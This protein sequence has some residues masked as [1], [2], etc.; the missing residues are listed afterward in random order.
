MIARLISTALVVIGTFGAAQAQD[1]IAVGALRFVSNGP[2]FMAVEKGFFKAE[3][4]EVDIRFFD[5]A[6]P[7]AVAVVSGDVEL[8][9]TAFTAGLF[10]LA[11][12][13][14]L[15][16]IAAQAKE[17]KGYEGNNVLASNAAWE[18]GVRRLEDLPGKSLGI[19]QVGSSF[20][21]QIG[22]I[23]RLKGFDVKQVDLRPLQSLGNMS[24][25][26]K[27]SQVDAIIIAPHI[28]RSLLDAGDAKLI[29]L[30][31]ALDE[32][33]FGGLF[34]SPRAITT[35][36]AVVEKFVRAYQKGAAEF[37]GALLRLDASGKRIFDARSKEAA[38]MVAKYV[39]P[40]QDPQKAADRVEASTFYVD[41]QARLDVGDI[42]R[43]VAWFKSQGMIDAS[44]DPKS[45][46]DLSFV[47]GHTNIPQ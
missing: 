28:A 27:G 39:A 37:H 11:G 1:K 8:G 43:Q 30:Y 45:F 41:P 5:A 25:A 31:S 23:A 4:L 32:Y 16:V 14:A 12:K 22:Q 6:Q 42:H 3:G 19:T 17:Q 46:I 20:H 26:L 10:N 2:L 15:K 9:A 38:V 29:G 13:G 7:I 36:R 44:V 33:Q 35:R 47:Q 18:K 24:A 21:Y 34:A 40:G